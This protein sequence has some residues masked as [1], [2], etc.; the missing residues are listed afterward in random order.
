MWPGSLGCGFL[1]PVSSSCVWARRER[2]REGEDLNRWTTRRRREEELDKSVGGWW[3]LTL[4]FGS[5]QRLRERA[6]KLVGG[7]G[8]D[9]VVLNGEPSRKLQGPEHTHTQRCFPRPSQGSKCSAAAAAA[10]Q[11]VPLPAKREGGRG[12]KLPDRSV[13]VPAP[14]RTALP[15]HS[16]SLTHAHPHPQAA[17]RTR[18]SGRGRG[19]G[20]GGG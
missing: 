2:E 15:T 18:A 19:P 10:T 17:T 4:V 8:G 20:S 6:G 7:S 16:H 13:L 3:L 14:P 5:T 9:G 11:Q 12:E 1:G